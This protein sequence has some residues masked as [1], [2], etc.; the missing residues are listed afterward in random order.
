MKC[1]KKKRKTRNFYFFYLTYMNYYT[2]IHYRLKS[3]IKITQVCNYVNFSNIFGHSNRC[4]Y[5][6]YLYI[7]HVLKSL[8]F[9]TCVNILTFN[10]HH[11]IITGIKFFCLLYA[12]FIYLIL[13]IHKFY[14]WTAEVP[15]FF[16]LRDTH[17]S[18]L[19][20]E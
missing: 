2:S 13:F 14:Q 18:R 19:P 6:V 7:T 11:N 15:N 16:L 1:Y 4:L 20:Y 9:D 3:F 5:S 17:A 8:N 10:H 12:R